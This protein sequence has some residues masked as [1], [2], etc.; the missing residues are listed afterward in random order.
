MH[1]ITL[2]LLAFLCFSHSINLYSQHLT[3]YADAISY[4]QDE[5]Y[6]Y[7]FLEKFDDNHLNWPQWTTQKSSAHIGWGRLTFRSEGNDENN[8]PFLVKE[9][10]PLDLNRDYII[11]TDMTT[12]GGGS[13]YPS[14]YFNWGVDK[15]NLYAFGFTFDTK[16]WKD[17]YNFDVLQNGRWTSVIRKPI[18]KKSKS[19]NN[20]IWFLTIEKKGDNI[21][22]Y[23]N[24]ELWDKVVC[25]KLNE[26]RQSLIGFSLHKE[27]KIEVGDIAIYQNRAIDTL[28]QSADFI[29][30]SQR[31]ETGDLNA[32]YQLANM[33][34][35]G[36]GTKKDSAKALATYLMA[37][38]KGHTLSMANA[39]F[40][41][42]KQFL[43]S[44]KKE[45]QTKAAQWYLKA[46]E[47]STQPANNY[48]AEYIAI[49]Y[50][51]VDPGERGYYN[52]NY[53]PPVESVYLAQKAQRKEIAS[54]ISA[55]AHAKTLPKLV[56]R[57]VSINPLDKSKCYVE[58]DSRIYP[59]LQL[60]QNDLK[61]L[62]FYWDNSLRDFVMKIGTEPLTNW[63]KQQA[64]L[65]VIRGYRPEL[66]W[67]N[68]IC[69]VC[70]GKGL[71]GGGQ[72]SYSYSVATGTY[73]TT[74]TETNI[75]QTVKVTKT[76]NYTTQTI[77]GYIPPKICNAC[78]GKPTERYC[79]TI[80]NVNL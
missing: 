20:T 52:K 13:F 7:A 72:G 67:Q 11:K 21:F 70:N 17:M 76:P 60:S 47:T 49:L 68:G 42:Y 59:F 79:N 35:Q 15:N 54:R 63:A 69:G 58:A 65:Y 44:G 9:Q 18:I 75:G 10:I 3:E 32:L 45:Y 77:K 29:T 43:A 34:W 62:D 40:I 14:Y 31:A 71:V 57:T 41:Y 66:D 64:S 55:N 5:I 74:T 80:I 38:E 22:F 12:I 36:L 6:E 39:A 37:A 24:N 33:H 8:W 50:P 73:T 2:P 56:A 46:S 48:F 51:Y 23:V 61:P 26:N 16:S 28:T 53:L 27:I 30:Y 19:G 78:H 25:P 4:K 1:R